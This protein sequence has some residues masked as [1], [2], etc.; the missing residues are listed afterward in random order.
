MATETVNWSQEDEAALVA[1]NAKKIAWA[2]LQT[3]L[4]LLSTAKVLL[5][6]ARDV[7]DRPPNRVLAVNIEHGYPNNYGGR[8]GPGKWGRVTL[9]LELTPE[10]L[11]H[12][13]RLITAPLT[14]DV[15]S[16]GRLQ[17]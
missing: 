10:V 2:E 8:P 6:V 16:G 11:D 7:L 14:V 4:N 13:N 3:Q 5:E 9:L 1:L 15:L 12:V 17:H